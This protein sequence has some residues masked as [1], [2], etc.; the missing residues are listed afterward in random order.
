M[1]RPGWQ[2]ATTGV[3]V[4]PCLG[5]AVMVGLGRTVT[6][7]TSF[8]IVGFSVGLGGMGVGGINVTVGRSVAVGGMGIT[9]GG[10][11]VDVGLGVSMLM[12]A[13]VGATATPLRGSMNM[14]YAIHTSVTTTNTRTAAKPYATLFVVTTL[15][16]GLTGSARFGSTGIGLLRL[17]ISLTRAS[18]FMASRLEGAKANAC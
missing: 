11:E 7:N 17:N 12:A 1:L 5:E 13:A 2:S 8:V 18:P 4:K 15:G 14:L 3:G 10:L 16:R 6:I 9:V